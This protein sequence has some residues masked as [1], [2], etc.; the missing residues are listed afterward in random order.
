MRFTSAALAS[1]L[2][3]ATAACGSDAAV[4]AH[5]LTDGRAVGQL[6]EADSLS[7]VLVYPLAMCYSCSPSHSRWEEVAARTG[8]ALHLV[9]DATPDTA[10]RR[11]LAFQRIRVSGVLA[12]TELTERVVP[13]ELLFKRGKLVASAI[14]REQV[15]SKQLW[16]VAHNVFP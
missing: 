13:S 9:L 4:Q 12:A 10:D 7:I 11:V 5:R 3:M 16:M 1:V 8:A 15:S 2:L 14:G 6:V